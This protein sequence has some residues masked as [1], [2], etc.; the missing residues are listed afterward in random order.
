[1]KIPDIA[2]I[3][4]PTLG[5]SPREEVVSAR[6]AGFTSIAVHDWLAPAGRSLEDLDR[7]VR[8]VGLTYAVSWPNT[9]CI[10]PLADGEGGTDI[11][12]RT[13]S[14]FRSLI[15]F[16]ELGIPGMAIFTGPVGDR[17]MDEAR[18]I[19]VSELRALGQ[20]AAELGLFIAF[21][22]MHT[23]LRK[24][25]SFLTGTPASVSLIEEV[26]LDNIKITLDIW[27]YAES[28]DPYA[29]VRMLAPHLANVH[30][31]DYRYPTRGWADRA[32]L[33]EG[34]APV[35]D[36]VRA[37]AEVDFQGYWEV[38]ILSDNGLF[39]TRHE[40]SLWDRPTP[41]LLNEARTAIEKTW[42][43]AFGAA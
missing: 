25:H 2:I 7:A 15:R 21:E 34:V 9:T 1:M 27:H 30:L 42:I 3:E 11:A 29:D 37:L 31:C 13:Q 23:S 20:A 40:D 35:V 18:D 8:E 17:S 24:T 22:P 19:V 38:E 14:M 32:L 10:L 39:G 5:T 33:G 41:Q 28:T 12:Q 43:R 26:G 6:D 36:F 16:A 4:F